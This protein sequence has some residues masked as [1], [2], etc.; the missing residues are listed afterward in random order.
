MKNIGFKILFFT[1]ILLVLADVVSTL[2]CGREL[3]AYLESNPVYKYGGLFLIFLINIAVYTYYWWVYNK[4]KI[5]IDDRYFAILSMCMIAGIRCLAIYGN[6][7][8]AF[9]EPQNIAEQ[10]DVTIEEAK[11]IQINTASTVTEE[12][13]MEYVKS[14]IYPNIL[15]IFIC[16]IAWIIFRFD[17]QIEVKEAK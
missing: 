13:K 12:Q 3:I 6:I 5:K 8:V 14:L 4:K 7:Q 2:L 17:H 15:P 11:E 9:V 1:S 16:V 10:L